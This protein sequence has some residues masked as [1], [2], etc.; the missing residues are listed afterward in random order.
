MFLA[1]FCAIASPGYLYD[2]LTKFHDAIENHGLESNFENTG[3]NNEAEAPHSAI[4]THC[5]I[6]EVEITVE[7]GQVV[8][9]VL[10]KNEATPRPA[11]TETVSPNPRGRDAPHSLPPD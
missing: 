11:P 9:I 7:G 1:I 3:H 5:S 6:G 8:I 2:K 10:D 4:C